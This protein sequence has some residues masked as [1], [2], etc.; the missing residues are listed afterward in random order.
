MNTIA[1][2]RLV[3]FTILTLAT[4]VLCGA[5]AGLTVTGKVIDENGVPV[6]EAQVTA[7]GQDG[8]SP[9]SGSSDPAGM[10]TLEIAAPGSYRIEAKRE[11]F[12]LFTN[13]SVAL[14]DGA[15]I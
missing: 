1:S 15:S 8:K 4:P 2:S 7:A 14:A 12:F 13:P 10:F 5:A 6:R 11:G 3:V 9:V